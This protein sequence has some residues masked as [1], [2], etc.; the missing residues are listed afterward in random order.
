MPHALH[1]HAITNF[2]RPCPDETLY[3]LF[4]R[5]HRVSGLPTIK[6]T[7]QAL[8]G[9]PYLQSGTEFPSYIPDL[10]AV[11]NLSISELVD[12]HT[13]FPFFMPFTPKDAYEK[14]LEHLRNGRAESSRKSLSLVANRLST[15]DYLQWC[16]VCLEEDIGKFGI[17]YW[18]RKHQ[19][20]G[21]TVCPN[22]AVI[23]HQASWKRHKAQLPLEDEY[24]D[25]ISRNDK[26]YVWSNLVSE[27]FHSCR[28]QLNSARVLD[29]YWI[30]LKKLNLA[31]EHQIREAE[32]REELKFFWGDIW[33]EST[34]ISLN[35]ITKRRL[36]PAC[37]FYNNKSSHHPLKHLLMV[38]Y[39]FAGWSDFLYF[40]HSGKNEVCPNNTEPP[41]TENDLK[42]H[43]WLALKEL[44]KGSSLRKAASIT[45]LSVTT[46]KSI[47]RRNQI[48]VSVRPK[49][50]YGF[51]E[52]SIWRQL[53]IGKTTQEIARFHKVSV[54]SVEQILKAH[55]KTT[56]LRKRIRFYRQ[57]QTKRNL[58][59]AILNKNQSHT[60]N[61]IRLIANSPYNWLFRNDKSWL[62]SQLPDETPRNK[63]HK[64]KR[65]AV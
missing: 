61:K 20:P 62:Y 5:Y 50:I 30:R 36:Y 41:D 44:E 3:S 1:G 7:L 27:Y 40:Y 15:N 25:V 6:D 43:K 28:C 10:A 4:W 59:I 33:E 54:G 8:T 65:K 56:E 14:S 60:R 52:R 13:L 11:L 16:P 46:V 39:L 48:P 47:A 63:R 22:H 55:P 31:N 32:L 17:R 49:K 45:G 58:L 64:N 21:L 37:L 38:G 51:I 24:S 12:N 29:T 23:L 35:S 42:S 19:L 9:H 18:H 53:F 26:Q 57:R 34:A 2:P